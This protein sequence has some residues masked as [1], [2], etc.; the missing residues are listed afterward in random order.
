[1]LM[2]IDWIGVLTGITSDEKFHQFNETVESVL[3][4]VA[5]IKSVRISAKKMIHRTMDDKRIGNSVLEKTEAIQKNSVKD[6]HR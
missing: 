5:P 3:N 1:M 2:N 6:Q 4:V